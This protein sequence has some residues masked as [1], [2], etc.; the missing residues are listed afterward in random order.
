MV[1]AVWGVIPV[2]GGLDCHCDGGCGSQIRK[3][4]SLQAFVSI[5]E[6]LVGNFDGFP[7]SMMAVFYEGDWHTPQLQQAKVPNLGLYLATAA[8]MHW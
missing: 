2:P 4:S 1:G 8:C 3:G 7:T 5:G 6:H